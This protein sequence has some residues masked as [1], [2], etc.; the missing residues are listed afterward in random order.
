MIKWGICAGSHDASVAVLKDDA[1]QF[2]AHSERYSRIKN[3]PNLNSDIISEAFSYGKPRSIIWYEDNFLKRT[4]QLYARQY[5]TAI[6]KPT[7]AQLLL[8]QGFTDYVEEGIH[9]DCHHVT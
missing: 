5:K 1:I 3:D 8:E 7:P 4:R 6:F 9:H 2:A